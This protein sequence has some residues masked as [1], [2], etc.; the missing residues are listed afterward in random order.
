[1]RLLNGLTLHESA[2][3]V[4]SDLNLSRLGHVGSPVTLE[5]DRAS[6]LSFELNVEP[7]VHAAVHTQRGEL[8]RS[9]ANLIGS[10]HVLVHDI[11]VEV[12]TDILDHDVESLV[13][14]GHL[15]CVLHHFGLELLVARLQLA[16][17][18]HLAEEV[19][20]AGELGLD[21]GEAKSASR[22]SGRHLTFIIQL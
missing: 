6:L 10:S 9:G 14:L 12:V 21:H 13:P 8:D 2:K 1:M 4:G 19:G 15:A 18:V 22:C 7:L 5:V 16:E 3:H 11:N 17:G 20:V